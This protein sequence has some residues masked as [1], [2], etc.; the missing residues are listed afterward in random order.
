MIVMLNRIYAIAGT[1]LAFVMIAGP[2]WA[3]RPVSVPEP[4]TMTVM[5]VGVGAAFIARKFLGRK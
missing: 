1:S 5:A 3:G 2:S 4:A